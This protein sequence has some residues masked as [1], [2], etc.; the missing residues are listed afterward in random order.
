G[1]GLRARP[2]PRAGQPT[3]E[4]TRPSHRPSRTAFLHGADARAT[5]GAV[6]SG[7]AR[8]RT[9]S[10]TGDRRPW[11]LRATHPRRADCGTADDDPKPQWW[12]AGLPTR[13][14]SAGIGRSADA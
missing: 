10:R 3:V 14:R 5:D 1:G 11:S 12:A 7:S 6:H 4:R 8:L 13:E 2:E 9:A